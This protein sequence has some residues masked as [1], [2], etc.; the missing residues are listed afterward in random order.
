[1]VSASADGGIN[2]C[3]N[4]NCIQIAVAMMNSLIPTASSPI[5]RPQKTT[6]PHKNNNNNNKADTSVIAFTSKHTAVVLSYLAAL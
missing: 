5:F 6:P 4:S 1:M 2:L 3:F